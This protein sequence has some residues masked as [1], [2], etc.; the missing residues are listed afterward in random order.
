MRAGIGT[1]LTWGD[2]DFVVIAVDYRHAVFRSI[3]EDFVREVVVEELL[4]MPDIVWHDLRP[5]SHEPADVQLIAGLPEKE[6]QVVEAWA[7]QLAIVKAAV[8][9]GQDAAFLLEDVRV[10]M[11]GLVEVNS[12]ETV[13]RKF[14]RFRSEGVLGLIDKRRYNGRKPS[15]DLR[16]ASAL[17]ASSAPRA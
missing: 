1:R 16:V 3:V 17:R 7:E 14:Q 11:S 10:A 8:E 6:R 4:R 15:L 13:R 12:V 5:P 9:A 2:Q